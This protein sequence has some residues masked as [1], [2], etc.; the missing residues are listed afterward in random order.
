MVFAFSDSL[1]S[2]IE[3][4]TE[5]TDLQFRTS[6]PEEFALQEL[7]LQLN[8]SICSCFLKI[9]CLYSIQQHMRLGFILGFEIVRQEYD[10]WLDCFLLLRFGNFFAILPFT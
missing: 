1:S 7:A 3:Q 10:R 2:N 5:S 4:H 9:H 6:L 8:E